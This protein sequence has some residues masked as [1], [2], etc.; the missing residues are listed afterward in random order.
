MHWWC[1]GL[2]E[3]RWEEG[4]QGKHEIRYGK[5]GHWM[6]YKDPETRFFVGPRNHRRGPEPGSDLLQTWYESHSEGFEGTAKLRM[7]LLRRQPVLGHL[8]MKSWYDESRRNCTIPQPAPFEISQDRTPSLVGTYNSFL[9][10]A[11]MIATIVASI[12][13]NYSVEVST[14]DEA[15][16]D[17]P[18]QE[19]D[20]QEIGKW[21]RDTELLSIEQIGG[22]KLWHAQ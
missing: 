7:D 13:R 20:V 9:N 19:A 14:T 8:V 11:M 22:S 6:V 16:W 2:E 18:G 3:H 12:S 10:I 17:V 5:S 4:P 1:N 21:F 15:R